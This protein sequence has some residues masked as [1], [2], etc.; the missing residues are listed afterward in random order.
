MKPNSS[1]SSFIQAGFSLVE[2]MVGMVIGLLATL[3]IVQIMSA[4]EAQKRVTTGNADAQ[5]NGGITLFGIERDLQMA[6]FALMFTA[7]PPLPASA[8]NPG[9][10]LRCQPILSENWMLQSALQR[11]LKIA[12]PESSS[13]P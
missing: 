13:A 10:P 8:P 4:F 5:T 2:I 1:H 11:V 6:G 9:S 7:I 12:C 3:V